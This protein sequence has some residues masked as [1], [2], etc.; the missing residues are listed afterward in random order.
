MSFAS[1]KNLGKERIQQLLAA[2]GSKPTAD[3]PVE[4]TAYN[5]RQPHCFSS[6]E[7]ARLE[8]I[9]K[10]AGAA[11]AESLAA[12]FRSDCTVTVTS[13]SQH[14]GREFV[15]K[16]LHGEGDGY[17][18]GVGP[19]QEHLCGFVSI[20]VQTAATLVR[21]LLG[22]GES[23]KGSDSVLS[24]LEESLLSDIGSA[25][26]AA[27]TVFEGDGH[28]LQPAQVFTR[29]ELPFELKG[30]DEYFRISF[31]IKKGDSQEGCEAHVLLPCSMLTGLVGRIGEVDAV[32]AA[33]DT[34]KAMLEHVH[35]V[36]VSVTAQLAS[37]VLTFEQIMNLCP[38]DILVLDKRIDEPIEVMVEGKALL[39]GQP[40]K[41]AGQ[42]AVIITQSPSDR[43]EA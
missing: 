16:V 9:T 7:L 23:E 39:R 24:Q 42:Y 11:M 25:I 15:D 31:S 20:P 19:D 29:G 13:A 40:A 12:L 41:A 34:K 8:T 5:W 35:Q 27:L 3:T 22:D 37:M 33:E 32:I 26:V 4:A 28:D 17:Y 10:K 1:T 43:G 38:S 21:Q 6:K 18:L 36:P 14:F 30:A 2:V